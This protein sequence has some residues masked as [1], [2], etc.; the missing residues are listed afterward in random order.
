MVGTPPTGAAPGHAPRR[1]ARCRSPE[2]PTAAL[3]VKAADRL[4][5]SPEQQCSRTVR[6]CGPHGL[7]SRHTRCGS[8]FSGTPLLPPQTRRHA[9]RPICG[10]TWFRTCPDASALLIGPDSTRIHSTLRTACT[11]GLIDLCQ[12]SLGQQVSAKCRSQDVATLSD[13]ETLTTSATS[14]SV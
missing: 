13:C 5:S 4:G 9:S 3:A 10:T 2:A 11:C 8:R 7:A 1:S 12:S 6:G 14:I